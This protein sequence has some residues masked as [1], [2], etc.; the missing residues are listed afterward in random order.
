MG[1]VDAIIATYASSSDCYRREDRHYLVFHEF[2][3]GNLCLPE[4]LMRAGSLKTTSSPSLSRLLLAVIVV[5]ITIDAVIWYTA[6]TTSLLADVVDI[7]TPATLY[8]KLDYLRELKGH[9]IVF[10]GDS[11]VYGRRMKEA[12]DANWRQHTIPA[13]VERILHG[14][15]PQQPFPIMNLAL[16]GALPADI[17]H[18][19]RLLSPLKPDCIVADISLRAFST[20]FSREGDRYSRPWLPTMDVDS[21]FNLHNDNT[22]QTWNLRIENNL[23]DFALSHWR[24]YR[25]RDFFQ[26]RVFDG[27]PSSVIRRLRDWLDQR[28]GKPPAETDPL[29]DILL[30]IK[31]KNRYGTVTLA[32][33][34]PQVIALKRTLD[35]LASN[36]QCAIFFY[37]TEEKKQ[38]ASMM[39]AQ[40]YKQLQ[41]ALAAIFLPYRNRGILFLPPLPDIG[42]EYYLDYG[43]LNDAGNAIVAKNIVDNGLIRSVPRLRKEP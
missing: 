15:F 23:Q 2:E 6:K 13:H 4:F 26:W 25:M 3:I 28:L 29:D 42:K 8:A 34:N 16:N 14:R 21:S 33:D 1:G 5:F 37:A 19:V 22:R 32:D 9:R 35:R 7:Q 40:R 17:E 31:A 11:V 20:D 38:L 24:L 36:T 41:D 10:V 12:G 27:E 43:H 39:D 30:A 18:I